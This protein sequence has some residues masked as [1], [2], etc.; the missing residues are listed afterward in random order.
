MAASAWRPI[1][2]VRPTQGLTVLARG[3]ANGLLVKHWLTALRWLPD[4]WPEA[5]WRNLDLTA[6]DLPSEPQEWAVVPD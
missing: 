1:C 6:A 4:R 3:P 5:P 2:E